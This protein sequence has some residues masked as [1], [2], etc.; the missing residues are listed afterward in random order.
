M[1]LFIAIN[2]DDSVKDYFTSVIDKLKTYGV[3]GSFLHR[4]NLHLT[5]VFINETDYVNNIKNDINKIIAKSFEMTFDIPEQIISV[6]SISLMKSEQIN[7]KL[8]YTEINSKP[9]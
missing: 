4:D 6:N 8:V 5:L 2:F 1:R 7:G 3:S 9:L